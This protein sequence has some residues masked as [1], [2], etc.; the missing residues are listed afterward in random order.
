MRWLARWPACLRARLRVRLRVRLPVVALVIAAAAGLPVAWAQ[1]PAACPP[2]S[3]AP[4]PEQIKAAAGA[5]RD[6]GMLWRLRKDGRSAWLYGTV[7]VSKLEWSFPGPELRAALAAADTLALEL[8]VTDPA[9]LQRVLR[10]VAAAG[11]PPLPAALQGRIAAL[12]RAACLPEAALAGQHP[13]MQATTLTVL[14]ARWDGL[15]PGYGL[16]SVL[17]GLAHAAGKPIVSLE[18]PE[19]QIAALIPADKAKALKLAEGMVE[20]LEQGAPRRTLGRLAQAWERGDLAELADYERWC[21]CAVD[22]EDRA[23]MRRLNDERNPA[24]ADAIDALQRNGK[25]VFAAVGALH[26]TGEQALP[27]LMAQRGYR[28]ERVLFAPR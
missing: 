24:L 22:A 16:E 17:A 13:V 19:L 20:Q 21:D 2:V 25:A 10:A 28:V 8:D 6:R 7:H 1:S 15:D 9:I 18:T 3:G 27:R 26:M 5:A 11:A 4:T 23:F 12:A 14:A